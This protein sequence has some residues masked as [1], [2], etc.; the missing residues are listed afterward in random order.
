MDRMKNPT[1]IAVLVFR[2]PLDDGGEKLR[3]IVETV[4][5][6]LK[7]LDGWC[8]TDEYYDRVNALMVELGAWPEGTG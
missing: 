7:P 4:A 3:K 1:K 5:G 2:I 8:G 6:P